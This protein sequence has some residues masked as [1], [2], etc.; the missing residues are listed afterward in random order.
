MKITSEIDEI[1]GISF[2]GNISVIKNQATMF[3][4][5]AITVNAPTAY[6]IFFKGNIYF[7][8]NSNYD[9]QGY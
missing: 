2:I 5:D 7:G 9:S 1:H 6:G 4:F 8:N 3:I